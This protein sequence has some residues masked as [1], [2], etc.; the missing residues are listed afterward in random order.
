[1]VYKFIIVTNLLPHYTK[2][3][4][5]IKIVGLININNLT[6]CFSASLSKS[7]NNPSQYTL[8]YRSEYSYLQG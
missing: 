7:F 6:I 3:T 8:S 1:M 4:S 2:G 5:T